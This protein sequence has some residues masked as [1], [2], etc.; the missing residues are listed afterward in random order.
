MELGL[1]EEQILLGDAIGQ[2]CA[3]QF[4]LGALRDLERAGQPYPAALWQSLSD[5]GIGGLAV[6]EAWGG[7]GTGLL[8]V[9]LAYGQF[10]RHLLPS[11]HW[12]SAVLAARL[13]AGS[14]DRAMAAAW[15]PDIVAGRRILTVASQQPG[16]SCEHLPG[17]TRL[18]P[19]GDGHRLD[20][21]KIF[22]P[23]AAQADGILVLAHDGDRLVACM[24]SPDAEGL[25]LDPQPNLAGEAYASASFRNVAVG[26]GQVLADGADIGDLWRGVMFQA[27][28][29]LAAQAVG[30][31][32]RIHEISV[33]YAREREAFGRPIGGFQAIAHDLADAIVTIEGCQTLVHQ[34]AWLHDNGRPYQVAAAIAKLQ[35]CAMFRRV[36]ALGVQI[37]GGLGYTV[38]GDPQLFFRRAKQWQVLNW[39][40][41]R[42]EDEIARLTLDG[43]I[44]DV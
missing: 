7:L 38:E 11:P 30:A 1:S 41:A 40:E 9:A 33:A 21:H 16:M 24:V 17:G 10:G 39:D 36:S 25:R 14:G 42:L 4:P 6:P 22:V 12:V 13:L 32:R 15:L 23:F 3:D 27:L 34:A 26:R 19:C 29:P 5:M 31:A 43:G 37:H 2:I 20:G 44:G 35:A 28:V 8:D 18:H